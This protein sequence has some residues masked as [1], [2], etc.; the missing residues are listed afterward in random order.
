M[1]QD[2]VKRKKKR[3][4]SLSA[5]FLIALG[6]VIIAG[7]GFWGGIAYQKGH[8]STSSSASSNTASTGGGSGGGGFGGRFG[9]GSRVI[10]PVTA[11]SPTSI[12]VSNQQTGSSSTLTIT[13]STVVTD[14]GQTVAASSIQV[15]NTVFISEDSTD[16]SQA[17]RIL[18]NPSFGGFNQQNSTPNPSSNSG[19]SSSSGTIE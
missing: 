10:G 16:T 11:V 12:T 7:L 8:Q 17:S 15:G 2:T 9:G 19:S 14:N 4:P 6:G 5:I 18:V 13:S 1:D 3:G